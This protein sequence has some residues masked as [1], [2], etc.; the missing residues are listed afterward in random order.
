[1]RK[2]KVCLKKNLDRSTHIQ[3]FDIVCD[4]TTLSMLATQTAA[5]ILETCNE[6]SE[7]YS[8]R[9]SGV[10]AILA[11]RLTNDWTPVGYRW[12]L[13]CQAE[14]LYCIVEGH[15]ENRSSLI[16]WGPEERQLIADSLFA[17]QQ[18]KTALHGYEPF[19]HNQHLDWDKK[20]GV[21]PCACN[22]DW[23]ELNGRLLKSKILTIGVK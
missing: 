11:K 13:L 16:M 1:M 2:F 21:I 8:V 17:F 22:K 14:F 3:R 6:Y 12:A 4:S 19:D 20:N 18:W 23:A 15:L 9:T 7:K 10:G 5:C